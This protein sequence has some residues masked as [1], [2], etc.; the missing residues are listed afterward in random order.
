[1]NEQHTCISCENTFSGPYC[2]ECGEKVLRQQDRTIR[3]IIGDLINALTFAETKLWVT[4]KSVLLAPGQF[5]SDWV[6]G[7]RRI[8]MKPISVFFL[9]NFI[10]F[11]IPVFN[12]FNTNL[13]IQ[14]HGFQNLHSPLAE[15]WV[16]EQVAQMDI[17]YEDYEARYDAKSSELSKLLLITVVV[18][19]AIFFWLIHL[20][21]ERNLIAD[22]LTVSFE[23]M[24]FVILFALQMVGALLAGL[25]LMGMKFLSSEAYLT[26]IMLLIL[27]YFLFRMERIFYR[28]G[29]GRSVINSLLCLTSFIVVLF[30]YRVLLF[31]VTYWSV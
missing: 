2:N 27:Y 15:R 5:S 21:S 14:T 8:Y 28:F 30:A 6:V 11:L 24:T 12:T 3:H 22:H 19:M 23:L 29:I 9:A 7:K 31:F 16:N 13:Y 4:L 17:A 10:Y 25:S 1:M 26:T 18:F 20:G